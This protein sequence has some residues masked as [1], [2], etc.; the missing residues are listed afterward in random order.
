MRRSYNREYLVTAWPERFGRHRGEQDADHVQRLAQDAWLLDAT[1]AE[2]AN[3]ADVEPDLV[4]RERNRMARDYGLGKLLRRARDVGFV[5]GSCDYPHDVIYQ[6]LDFLEA[7]VR[8]NEGQQADAGRSGHPEREG[9]ESACSRSQDSRSVA[10]PQ[11]QQ[12]GSRN[13]MRDAG[14]SQDVRAG[15]SKG[16]RGRPGET[17]SFGV[18]DGP[19]A[20]VGTT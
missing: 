11:N 13:G 2:L 19:A 7:S 20:S 4:R 3:I 12:R 17:G 18:T 8:P 16:I 1:D 6:A 14:R 10:G 5:I 9:A 15:S